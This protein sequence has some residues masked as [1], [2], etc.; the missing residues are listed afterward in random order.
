MELRVIPPRKRNPNKYDSEIT[1]EIPVKV[2]QIHQDRQIGKIIPITIERLDFK[3]GNLVTSDAITF[4]TS[5]ELF[6]S[7]N[8][9]LPFYTDC[10]ISKINNGIEMKVIGIYNTGLI[11]NAFKV[12]EILNNNETELNEIFTFNYSELNKWLLNN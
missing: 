9:E 7:L 8:L 6:D 3:T 10:I 1:Y 5:T 2:L 11:E 12:A 4:Q